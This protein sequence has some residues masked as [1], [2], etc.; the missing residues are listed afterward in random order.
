M[1]RPELSEADFVEGGRRSNYLIHTRFNGIV[2]EHSHAWL[3]E[4]GRYCT[5][6]IY[7]APDEATVR[8]HARELGGHEIVRIVEIVDDASPADFPI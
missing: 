5:F 4:D 6:C 3:N 1:F 7:S 8:D 2:W